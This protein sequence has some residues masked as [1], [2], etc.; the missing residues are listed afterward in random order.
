MWCLEVCD[1]LLSRGHNVRV[2]ASN[3]LA[4]AI[5]G[6]DYSH[7]LRELELELSMETGAAWRQFAWGKRRRERRNLGR[8]SRVLAE[9]DP[10]VVLIWAMWNLPISLAA[11]AEA[12]RPVVYYVGDLWPLE[13]SQVYRYL[14]T[15]SRNPGRRWLKQALARLAAASLPPPVL[16]VD[17]LRFQHA[18]CPSRF[19]REHLRAVG[20]PAS[21][22]AI[23]QGAIDTARFAEGNPGPAL[24]RGDRPFRLLWVG[25]V[26][27]GKGVETAIRAV[28][29]LARG[30]GLDVDLAVVGPGADHYL[31]ALRALAAAEGVDS[32]VS[33]VGPVAQVDLPGLYGGFDAFVFTSELEESFGRVLVEAMAAG[34]P[35]VST[36]GASATNEILDDG[37]FGLLFKP[38]D[39]DALAQQISRLAC[40]GELRRRLSTEARAWA[41]SRFDT[42]R[43]V[44][45]IEEHLERAAAG[46]VPAEP[47]QREQASASHPARPVQRSRD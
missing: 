29:Q 39:W 33:F 34:I 44:R 40:D 11:L 1:G 12:E 7:V 22:L 36:A 43:M 18:L 30:S 13:P 26:A 24:E 31:R 10:D 8:L 35:V 14:D 2:L 20:V 42:S 21:H 17:V 38:G 16:P 32:L 47:D 37:R 45:E 4:G 27:E 5:T 41:C 15:P 46:A 28:G 19:I 9:F 3:H 6:D 23:V 25:R